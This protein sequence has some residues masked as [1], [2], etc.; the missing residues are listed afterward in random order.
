MK[1]KN[2]TS[3]KMSMDVKEFLKNMQKNRIKMDRKELYQTECLELIVKYF[4]LNNVSYLDMI[5]MEL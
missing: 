4:K 5:K 1:D 3:V 2:L